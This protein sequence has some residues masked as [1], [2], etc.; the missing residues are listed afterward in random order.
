MAKYF[1]DGIESV[2]FK[3]DVDMTDWQYRLVVAASTNDNVGKYSFV[4]YGSASPIPIGILLNDPSAGQE[5]VVQCLGFC[6]AV[7]NVPGTGC[8]LRLGVHLK[9]VSNGGLEAL[10]ATGSYV[11][12]VIL[13]R[14]LGPR[15]GT[16]GS[17]LGNVLLTG[18][19]WSLSAGTVPIG[20]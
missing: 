6:K 17:Y 5:A 18:V 13:G 1:S 10:S 7:V 9:A 16:A 2:P 12:D 8:D 15:T 20:L 14:Y 4:I 11:N 19:T 3:A